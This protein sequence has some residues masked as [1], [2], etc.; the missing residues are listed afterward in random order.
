[1]LARRN[2]LGSWWTD[3]LQLPGYDPIATAG[4][5]RFDLRAAEQALGFFTQILPHSLSP[6]EEAIVL[7]LWGWRQA[8]GQRRY[9][10]GVRR[11]L[12]A[13]CLG[14]VVRDAGPVGAPCGAAPTGAAGDRLLCPG[15]PHD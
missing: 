14:P 10:T 9:V 13:G 3:H 5:S 6:W 4:S 7:N 12:P 15:R 8:Q 11:A 1:M 2:P